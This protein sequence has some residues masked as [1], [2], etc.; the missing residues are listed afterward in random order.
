MKY[1]IIIALFLAETS[2]AGELTLK[3]I[4]EHLSDMT[5]RVRI[6]DS[7]AGFP[8]GQGYIRQIKADD[9]SR[10]LHIRDLPNGKYAIA[11]FADSNKNEYLDKNLIG[12]PTEP[13]GF[14]NN[15][16]NLFGPPSFNKAAFEVND[17][18]VVLS[19]HLY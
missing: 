6:F 16:R 15:V 2:H 4:G 10:D 12:Q 14:S 3:F 11:A 18:G 1:T 17:A 5:I 19:I 13:Y 8:S 9:A 7:P